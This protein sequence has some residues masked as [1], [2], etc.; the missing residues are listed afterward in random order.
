MNKPVI[1]IIMPVLNRGDMIEKAIT[2]V[3]NQHYP[4]TELIILDGGSSD[5][6]L[7]IIKRYES[8]IT[9][10]HSS[11]DGSAA[12]ATNLGIEKAKGDLIALLMADDY[13]EAGLFDKIA[14]AY[15]AHPEADM[16]SCAGRVIAFDQASQ[17]YQT[18]KTYHSSRKLKL[19]FYNICYGTSAICFRFIKKSLHERIGVYIPFHTDKKQMLTNDK[20]F[21]L[22]AVLHG[23]RNQYV[24]H[25]G[26]THVAHSGSYSFGNHRSTFVRHCMEHMDIA[27]QY[28]SQ[29]N[30][31]LKHQFFLSTWYNDQSAKLFLFHLLKGEVRA[32]SEIMLGSIKI[33]PLIWPASLAVTSC[34]LMLKQ[35]LRF[36]QVEK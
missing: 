21:L 23:V 31:S 5:N 13:Y 35:V 1:S 2:S 26:Y 28:L 12:Y 8:E 32:A 4:H 30:L 24:D 27:R 29:A 25:L 6:T 20:E 11:P 18:Q 22:R 36:C 3:L 9:Y 10:W 15:L 16:F 17:T 19:S 14:E 7:D 34:R 33:Y